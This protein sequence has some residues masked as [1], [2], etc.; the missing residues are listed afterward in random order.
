MNFEKKRMNKIN[1][2]LNIFLSF[3]LLGLI[4]SAIYFTYNY[5]YLEDEVTSI[6]VVA[7][8]RVSYK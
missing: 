5:A 6:Q 3:I 4:I 8:E 7:N 2:N 1:K